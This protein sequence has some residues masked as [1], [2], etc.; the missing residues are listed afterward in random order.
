VWFNIAGVIYL[1]AGIDRVQLPSGDV[2]LSVRATDGGHH[3]LSTVA[4]LRVLV[5]DA[6][7]AANETASS[8]TVAHLLASNRLATVLA[9]LLAAILFTIAAILL[10]A[11]LIDRRRCR[12]RDKLSVCRCLP[13]RW[14]HGETDG[15]ATDLFAMTY[16][17]CCCFVDEDMQQQRKCKPQ[18]STDDVIA[19]TEDV[20]RSTSSVL[21]TAVRRVSASVESLYTVNV[22]Q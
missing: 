18:L 2:S 16:C 19:T 12:P 8:S 21:T 7:S 4:V 9:V 3:P 10:S 20:S 15:N 14:R 5:H 11:V 6:A 1:T 17:C 22:S 13:M